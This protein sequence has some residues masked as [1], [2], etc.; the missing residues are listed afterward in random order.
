MGKISSGIKDL[1]S[2]LDHLHIGDNVIW[3]VEA[4]TNKGGDEG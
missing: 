4:G 2:L 1:D 3:E